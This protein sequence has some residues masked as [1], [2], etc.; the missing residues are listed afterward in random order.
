MGRNVGNITIRGGSYPGVDAFHAPLS[1]ASGKI[2][3]NMFRQL[4]GVYDYVFNAFQAYYISFMEFDIVK[5]LIMP[6]VMQLI[7]K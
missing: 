3:F 1:E 6:Y 2:T 4:S 7:I 5:I